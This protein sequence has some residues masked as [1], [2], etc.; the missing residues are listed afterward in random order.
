MATL[1]SVQHQSCL[2]ITW[3]SVS[4]PARVHQ[5]IS[6]LHSCTYLVMLAVRFGTTCTL[7]YITR[8]R[9]IGPANSSP[10]CKLQNTVMLSPFLSFRNKSRNWLIQRT[11]GQMDAAKR[12]AHS[13]M[14]SKER[15]AESSAHENI[16]NT[17]RR[18]YVKARLSLVE[19]IFQKKQHA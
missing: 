1:H 8:Y 16:S 15:M 7:L 18:C 12:H 14:H 2:A 13:F 3:S 9:T 11:D 10:L 17:F 19:L 5:I 4:L 6:F